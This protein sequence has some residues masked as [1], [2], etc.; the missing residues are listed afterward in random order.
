MTALD[1]EVNADKVLSMV[2]DDVVSM[3]KVVQKAVAVNPHAVK[4]MLPVLGLDKTVDL[5]DKNTER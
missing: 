5:M 3:E 4:N 2:N 1:S